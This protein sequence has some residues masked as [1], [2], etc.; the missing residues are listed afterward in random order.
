MFQHGRTQMIG[1]CE[2]ILQLLL[3]FPSHALFKL[4]YASLTGSRNTSMILN[5]AM[6]P[7]SD[8]ISAESVIDSNICQRSDSLFTGVTQTP[9]F[10]ENSNLIISFRSFSLDFS[11][12]PF[13]I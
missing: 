10:I 3:F 6:T 9:V 2:R 7:Q 1:T 8:A 4:D 5:S 13:F 11:N 12:T